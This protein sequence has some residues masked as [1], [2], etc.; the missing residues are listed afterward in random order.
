MNFPSSGAPVAGPVG[1]GVDGLRFV[2]GVEEQPAA[3]AD[4]AALE[5][6]AQGAS[7][8]I[9]T[10]LFGEKA[11]ARC[12]LDNDSMV[13]PA[14]HWIKNQLDV[15][16]AM[17]RVGGTAIDGLD[18]ANL[19]VPDVTGDFGSAASTPAAT[20]VAGLEEG[21]EGNARVDLLRVRRRVTI[22]QAVEF[23]YGSTGSVAI[24]WAAVESLQVGA[25][26][27]ALRCGTRTPEPENKQRQDKKQRP[28]ISPGRSHQAPRR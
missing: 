4:P 22:F 26:K 9:F 17:S 7:G 20:V 25:R 28:E 18:A 21:G 13:L 23:A 10:A 14:A 6:V 11:D 16:V 15:S 1:G 8:P 12:D 27:D 2:L 24:N 3:D 5:T 19:D